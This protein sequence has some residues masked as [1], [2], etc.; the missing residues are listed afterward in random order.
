MILFVDKTGRRAK[1]AAQIF[2]FMGI[3]ATGATPSAAQSE[4]SNRYNT[5]VIFSPEDITAADELISNLKRL[6]LGAV[7]IAV[8]DVNHNEGIFTIPSFDLLIRGEISSSEL[9]AKIAELR[10]NYEKPPLGEYKLMGLDASVSNKSLLYFDTPIA[11]TKTELMITRLLIKSYPNPLQAKD[12]LKG[13]FKPDKLPL[14]SNVRTHV[15]IINKK[16]KGSVGRN[17]I[18]LSDDRLGYVLATPEQMNEK[19][20]LTV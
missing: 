18:S 14:L 8:S 10:K 5:I 3:L 19:K 6:S 4:I 12:I 11:L 9:Y 16:F 15:S 1:T 17:L 2:N 13:A 7:I 20:L